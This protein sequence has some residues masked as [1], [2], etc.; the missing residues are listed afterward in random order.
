MFELG[1]PVVHAVEIDAGREQS[2]ARA[3]AIADRYPPYD[4]PQVPMRA[5]STS[6]RD[7]R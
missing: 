3:S 7:R 4:P 6:L 2:E 1:R 5:G